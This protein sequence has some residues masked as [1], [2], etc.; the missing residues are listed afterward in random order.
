MTSRGGAFCGSFHPPMHRVECD[1]RA[2]ADA[3]RRAREEERTTRLTLGIEERRRSRSSGKNTIKTKTKPSAAGGY[4]TAEPPEEDELL[5]RARRLADDV[6][7]KLRVSVEG[8]PGSARATLLAMGA[9]RKTLGVGGGGGGGGGDLPPRLAIAS[10][11][12]AA[13]LMAS[14]GFP[15]PGGPAATTPTRVGARR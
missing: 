12:P 3:A 2:V 13:T 4:G 7:E 6:S 8:S 11:T 1:A 14:R 9:A 5:L 10:P 15:S